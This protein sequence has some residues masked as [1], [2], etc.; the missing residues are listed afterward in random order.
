MI[1]GDT[2][3]TLAGALAAAKLHI[4]IAHVEAGLRSYNRLMPEEINRV[5][6]DQLSDLLFCPSQVAVNNLATEGI[7]KGVSITGDVMADALQ[8]AATKASAHSH[9]LTRL[10]L[11]P[12]AYLVATVHR[13]ENTDDPARLGNIMAALSKLAKREAVVLPLHPRT[14][15]ILENTFPFAPNA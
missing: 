7:T 12:Q 4:R 6:A 5:V 14:K 2:N 1:Y 10:A 15:K 8:F 9:I 11:Q 3:S 13:A